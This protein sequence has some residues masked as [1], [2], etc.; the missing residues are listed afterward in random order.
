MKDEALI[1]LCRSGAFTK[2][3]ELM[4]EIREPNIIFTGNSN[5]MAYNIGK[6]DGFIEFKDSLI[7]IIKDKSNG[8]V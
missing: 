8:N 7:T 3:L 2:F 1:H 5:E 6:R 4:D